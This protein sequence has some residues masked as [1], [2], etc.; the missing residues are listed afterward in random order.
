MKKAQLG[1]VISLLFV[2]VGCKKPVAAKDATTELVNGI[3]YGKDPKKLKE[4]FV[5]DWEVAD[6]DTQPKRL[7]REL[8]ERFEFGE[9]YD[10]QLA[11]LS[12][13]L[14]SNL[15]QMT[16]FEV[17]VIEETAKIAK[18]EL[19]VIGLE[20]LDDQQLSGMIESQLEPELADITAETSEAQIDQ[21][22]NEISIKTLFLL[23]EN[24]ETKGDVTKVTLD[25]IAA[26]DERGKWVIQNKDR[27][28][29]DLMTAFSY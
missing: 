7:V 10:A 25:L 5:L 2:L 26:R 20:E 14:V 11:L 15:N 23:A 24:Q 17:T 22:V 19:A 28:I 9:E 21:L 3:I 4:S 27:F 6:D 16:S 29:R 13:R 12:E 8:K 18:V 1:I